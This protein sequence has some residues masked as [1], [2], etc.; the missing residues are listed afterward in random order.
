MAHM[1]IRKY[2]ELLPLQL[3]VE[4]VNPTAKSAVAVQEFSLSC[5]NGDV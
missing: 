1:I 2:L 4:L 5:H 3:S